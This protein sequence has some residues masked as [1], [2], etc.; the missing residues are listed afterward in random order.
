MTRMSYRNGILTT[1]NLFFSTISTD[2]HVAPTLHTS[3]SVMRT[4]FK[5]RTYPEVEELS[6]TLHRL[7]LRRERLRE[8]TESLR[9]SSN[10][11]RVSTQHLRTASDRLQSD[12]N[13]TAIG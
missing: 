6:A 8:Q 5:Q 11:L 4:S 13:G 7:Q 9:E 12:V 2:I 1:D 3:S 10:R